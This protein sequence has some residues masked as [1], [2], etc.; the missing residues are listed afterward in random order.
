MAP[1]PR[2]PEGKVVMVAGKPVIAGREEMVQEAGGLVTVQE[3]EE[4]L[5]LRTRVG[6]ALKELMLGGVTT[7]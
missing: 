6:V 4:A 2:V 3:R 7:H 1:V 5:P